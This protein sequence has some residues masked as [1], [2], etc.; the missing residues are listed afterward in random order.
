MKESRGMSAKELA[1]DVGISCEAGSDTTTRT[2][3]VFTL[4][5]ILYPD[6]MKKAQKET[7]A[8]IQGY[9]SYADKNRTF[10]H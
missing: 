3:E 6:V 10:L 5:M 8:T 7:N 2:L 4:A 1:Y 9:P